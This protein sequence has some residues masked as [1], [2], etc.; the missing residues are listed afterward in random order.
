MID[1]VGSRT[2]IK[3]HITKPPNTQTGSYLLISHEFNGGLWSDL[4]HIHSIPPPQRGDSA[5]LDHLPE[6]PREADAVCSRGVNLQPTDT[7]AVKQ[8]T[9]SR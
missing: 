1:Y 8:R 6:A 9:H 5:L 2:P 7:E 4:Q 3:T